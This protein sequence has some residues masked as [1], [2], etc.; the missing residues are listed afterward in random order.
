MACK[1]GIKPQEILNSELY[2]I[3]LKATGETSALPPPVIDAA[4]R[5]A[6]D[7]YE[8]DL[9]IF[10]APTQCIAEPANRG[11]TL[12]DG[13][14][15]VP[16]LDY[17]RDLF[18]EERWGWIDLDYRPVQSIENVFFSYPGTGFAQS[19]K[20]PVDWLRLDKRRGRI[21]IV[22][23]HG[24]AI[25]A[26]FNAYILS[27]LAGGRGLPQSI[28]TDFTAGLLPTELKRR[29]RYL[30]EGIKYRTALLLGPILSNIRTGG[31]NS[32]SLSMDGL[33]RNQ[34]FGSGKWGPYSGAVEQWQM[35]E[36]EA[37]ETWKNAEGGIELGVLGA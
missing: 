15:E 32:R 26:S 30:L 20:L 10:L 34:S 35:L 2:G 8:A 29:Y 13:Q 22:P 11:L 12:Q 23:T 37:R 5:A 25:L 24:E 9:Q 21:Q 4:L 33:S 27:I 14:V 3:L 31:L 19:Y 18:V 36:K 1:T 7:F 6:E 17:T 28:F 16:A